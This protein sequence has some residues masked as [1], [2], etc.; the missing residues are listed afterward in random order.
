MLLTPGCAATQPR[1]A[2][3]NAPLA[4]GFL[5]TTRSSRAALRSIHGASASSCWLRVTPW[6]PRW[7]GLLQICLERWRAEVIGRASRGVPLPDLGHDDPVR[8]IADQCPQAGLT[9]PIGGSRIEQIDVEGTRCLEQLNEL[10]VT[11]TIDRSWILEPSGAAKSDRAETQARYGYFSLIEPLV[12][13]RSFGI[14]VAHGCDQGILPIATGA[15]SAEPA[16]DPL[17]SSACPVGGGS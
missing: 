15:P 9:V 11:R 6:G 14:G 2:A 10:Q 5:T 3:V 16:F 12:A 1:L 4:R 7:P 8:I 13:G 17:T